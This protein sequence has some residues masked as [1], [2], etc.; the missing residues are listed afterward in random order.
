MDEKDKKIQLLEDR[1]VR[2][3]R[4]LL[5]LQSQVKHTQGR[6][7]RTDESLRRTHLNIDRIRR[8]LNR[9]V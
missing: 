1:V 2:L 9:R 7:V 4:V 8:E 6:A 3:E 5:Q